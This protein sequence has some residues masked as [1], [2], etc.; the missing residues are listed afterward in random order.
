MPGVTDDDGVTSVY[1]ARIPHGPMVVLSGTAALIWNEALSPEAEETLAARV[2]ARF[3]ST[4][5]L[6]TIDH[7]ITGFVQ[8]L[9]DQGLLERR[10]IS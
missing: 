4:I 7:D 1:I 9:I 3:E 10:Q 5:D 8:G 6:E 2:A